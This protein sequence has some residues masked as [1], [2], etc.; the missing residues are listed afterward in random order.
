MMAF[1]KEAHCMLCSDPQWEIRRKRMDHRPVEPASQVL[2]PVCADNGL[3]L[4]LRD[5][6]TM[7]RVDDAGASKIRICFYRLVK[8]DCEYGD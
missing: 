1:L 3:L 6:K 2:C 8:E 5:W 7:L 4:C